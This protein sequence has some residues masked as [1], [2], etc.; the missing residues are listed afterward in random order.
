MQLQLTNPAS[1]N[2]AYR[3]VYAGDFENQIGSRADG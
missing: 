3:W 1:S 2:Q